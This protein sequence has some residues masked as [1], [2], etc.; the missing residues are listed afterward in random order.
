MIA[1]RDAHSVKQDYDQMGINWETRWKVDKGQKVLKTLLQK[2][3]RL[4][5]AVELAP[6]SL[7]N[8]NSI[9]SRSADAIARTLEECADSLVSSRREELSQ[10]VSAK[11]PS[12]RGG[13]DEQPWHCDLKEGSLDGV[14][15]LA[16][17]TLMKV[18]A[19]TINEQEKSIAQ[20]FESYKEVSGLFARQM[21]TDLKESTAKLLNNL[22]VTWA[23]GLLCAAFGK[24]DNPAS[25][26]K[27]QVHRIK[28]Q[29]PPALWSQ[30]VPQLR[31]R[32]ESALRLKK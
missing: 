29:V 25:D 9:A 32:S 11:T 26:L 13:V 22:K 8:Q 12:S 31:Q 3:A 5:K 4:L 7:G 20:L 24:K 27:A 15:S 10:A 14:L 6:E 2:N 17:K 1:L 23:E 18:P 19:A 16:G 21:D 30:L 28:K